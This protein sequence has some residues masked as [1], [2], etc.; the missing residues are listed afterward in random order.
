MSLKIDIADRLKNL[1]PYLF[2]ELDR[3]KKEALSKG[4]DLID[5][6]VG[7]PDTPTPTHIIER[8]YEAAKDPKNHKYAT[9]LG[10]DELRQAITK[11]YNNRFGVKLDPQTEVLPLIGSK[12][13]ISH[14]PLAFLNPG[15]VALVPDP[16]YP[17]YKSGTILAG[18]VPYLMPLLKENNFLPVFKDI[19][20]QVAR[21]A[22]LMFINYP[23]NPTTATANKEFFEETVKFA[24]TN[25]IIVCHDAAYSEITFNNY[26]PMSFLEI[27]GAKEVGIEFHSLSKTYNMTGWRI[28]FALGNKE[29]IEN[30]AQVKSHIDSGIF[31]AVQFASI[32]ALSN[33]DHLTELLSTYKERRDILVEGLNAIGWK[34]DKPKA[35]FYVWAPVP[36]GYT[37]MELSKTLLD[38]CG[39]VTTPGIGF[40]Q[41]GEGFVRFALTV[42]AERIE[43]ALERIKT[44]HG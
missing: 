18:G 33:I 15:D 28:G 22:K 41:N 12:E 27:E 4:K 44:L 37:S 31:Q 42:E 36:P 1:P 2:A 8:L 16:C 29:V 11:W 21:R 7:D 26:K 25:N 5:F 10:L 20:Y 17:P 30:L 23:N 39:V 43:E 38:K 3:L 14:I 34:V 19:D 24:E 35:T 40:G 6:G 13:G 32:I 9:N